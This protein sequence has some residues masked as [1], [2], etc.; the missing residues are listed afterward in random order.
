M[1]K[2]LAMK[3]RV[4]AEERGKLAQ[5]ASQLKALRNDS[6]LKR[7]FVMSVSSRSFYSTGLFPDIV[8]VFFVFK[9]LS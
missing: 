7:D 5:K 3:P 8:Q 9:R 6:Q 2:I 4:S 1:R